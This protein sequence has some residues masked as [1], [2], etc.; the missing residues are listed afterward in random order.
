[1]IAPKLVMEW[2]LKQR[3]AQVKLAFE[4]LEQYMLELIQECRNLEKNAMIYI[5][6]VP[7]Q[8]SS[9]KTLAG[10]IFIFML[11]GH[12]TTAHTLAFTF[13]LLS[14]H[15]DYQEKL[16]K[17]IKSIIPDGRPPMSLLRAAIPV[18][19]H[20]IHEETHLLLSTWLSSMRHSV[21]SL[22]EY[23]VPHIGVTTIPKVAAEDTTLVTTDRV[24]NEVVVPVSRGTSL[25]ISVA[26]LHY[27]PRYW[28]DPLAFKPERF[29]GDWPREACLPFS[30]GAR[31]CLGRRSFETEGIA[32][33]TMLLSRYKIE[34]KDD[35]KFVNKT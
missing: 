8:T 1:M 20:Q 10:N 13:G 27:N 33:L 30:S 21:Y 24:G 11:A 34:L 23:G 17:H 32:I 28:D 29:H 26:A 19:R 5:A 7:L 25:Q 15:P 12:E 14:L 18:A 31:S 6:H 3:I 16:Y 2:A 4:E 22:G 35:L 9:Y